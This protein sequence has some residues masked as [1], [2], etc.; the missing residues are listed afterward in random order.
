MTQQHLIIYAKQKNLP[1]R[2]CN[3]MSFVS[4]Q[5]P[6]G[7]GKSKQSCPCFCMGSM[8]MICASVSA[9]LL[10]HPISLTPLHVSVLPIRLS[11]SG[12]GLWFPLVLKH[13]GESI[14]TSLTTQS[15]TWT[16]RER[17]FPLWLCAAEQQH[18]DKTSIRQLN[19][20]EDLAHDS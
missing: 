16:L 15:E 1:G 11:P 9:L 6:L 10:W 5:V 8:V 3:R 17:N 12:E 20:P 18:R 19:L 2:D 14:G 7:D 13:S 4:S